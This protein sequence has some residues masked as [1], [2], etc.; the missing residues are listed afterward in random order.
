MTEDEWDETQQ[1]ANRVLNVPAV[2][3]LFSGLMSISDEQAISIRFALMEDE[4]GDEEENEGDENEEFTLESPHRT[5]TPDTVQ[6]VPLTRSQSSENSPASRSSSFNLPG[7][8]STSQELVDDDAHID[9]LI[10]G[11]AVAQGALR[12]LKHATL[13]ESQW[14]NFIENCDAVDNQ[15]TAR[16][17]RGLA[18]L[19]LSFASL[20]TM[21]LYRHSEASDS[22]RSTDLDRLV[23]FGESAIYAV[24]RCSPAVPD[25]AV[26]HHN[27]GNGYYRRSL[28]I[29]GDDIELAIG[30][31]DLAIAIG[32]TAPGR[33]AMFLTCSARALAS[34]YESSHNFEDLQS[35]IDKNEQALSL[36]SSDDPTLNSTRA[37]CLINGGNLLIHRY[38]ISLERDIAYLKKAISY[39]QE[40]LQLCEQE[41]S[42]TSRSLQ[43]LGHAKLR[44]FF[45]TLS[46][47]SLAGAVDCFEKASFCN[48]GH[49][50][51]PLIAHN[52]ALGHAF[53][54]FFSPKSGSH[55]G[56]ADLAKAI[57][58]IEKALKHRPF[59]HAHR[60]SSLLIYNWCLLEILKTLSLF[61]E[62]HLQKLDTN[63][64]E[65]ER[66]DTAVVVT[67]LKHRASLAT[68]RYSE[69]K[70]HKHLVDSLQYSEAAMKT[71]QEFSHGQ[72][73]SF[74][75]DICEVAMMRLRVLKLKSSVDE[76]V[77]VKGQINQAFESFERA[78]SMSASTCDIM[79]QLSIASIWVSQALEMKHRSVALAYPVLLRILRGCINLNPAIEIKYAI[80]GI[81]KPIS[82]ADVAAAMMGLGSSASNLARAVEFLEYGRHITLSHIHALRH[83]EEK[84]HN[85]E[86]VDSEAVIRF[87][88]VCK[89]LDRNIHG[90]FLSSGWKWTSAFVPGETMDLKTPLVWEDFLQSHSNVMQE[91]E[92]A[93][94]QL[95]SEDVPATSRI[96]PLPSYADLKQA[97]N[98]GAIVIFNFSKYGCDALIIVG[99]RES[100]VRVSLGGE[101]EYQYFVSLASAL[102]SFVK[103]D[104]TVESDRK[105]QKVLKALWRKAVEPVTKELNELGVQIG[106]RL[107]LLPTG[108]ARLFPLHAADPY[109][110]KGFDPSDLSSLYTVSY[111]STLGTL[112]MAKASRTLARRDEPPK[113]LFIADDG[114]GNPAVEG[115]PHVKSEKEMIAKEFGDRATCLFREQATLDAVLANLPS[116]PW[117]QFGCHGTFDPE[118]PFQSCFILN[119]QSLTL[120]AIMRSRSFKGEFAFYSACNTASPQDPTSG[121]V[122]NLASAMEIC[123]FRSVVGT[124]YPIYDDFAADVCREFYRSARSRGW[125]D[126]AY[127]LKDSIL[128]LRRRMWVETRELGIRKWIA[129]IHIGI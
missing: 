29:S 118:R 17:T 55:Q 15:V 33:M 97:A 66:G 11:I 85:L 45:R 65:L 90:L 122:V 106:S 92:E 75:L 43:A 108:L 121:E 31:F 73:P 53:S 24:E 7:P 25:I 96:D 51:F 88:A 103:L 34:R 9:V 22:H 74:P 71:T 99:V 3:N 30:H 82:P 20:Y 28:T 127:S 81:L 37:I 94:A 60:P 36:L 116:H 57:M 126:V 35:A 114:E 62:S 48:E 26:I 39:L 32:S 54:Y 19:Y 104:D 58:W 49:I 87:E 84:V 40:T 41:N 125:T 44:Y 2:T 4:E 46:P 111:I 77:T 117:V 63:L 69:T 93:S 109:K 59:P 23:D 129:Y 76:D 110:S 107:W 78:S 47:P 61:Q 10:Y 115:L 105:L 98:G 8:S 56:D 102:E 14:S 64:Q 13:D 112:S 72:Y 89:Q 79:D 120:P 1:N 83:V 91:R 70:D 128:E 95:L 27:V 86:N 16:L 124:M 5:D 52:L 80:A 67:A 123:G 6:E 113:I 42:D 12:D 100:P 38:D 50:S 21:A 68:W 101:K 18:P 119:G